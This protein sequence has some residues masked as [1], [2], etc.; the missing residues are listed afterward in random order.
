MHVVYVGKKGGMRRVC[1]PLGSGVQRD[2]RQLSSGHLTEQK[3][4][5]GDRGKAEVRV[6]GFR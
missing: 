4:T 6:V 5:P 1:I 3:G 2:D